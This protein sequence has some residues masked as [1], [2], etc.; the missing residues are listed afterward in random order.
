MKKLARFKGG[1]KLPG[2]KSL[3]NQAPIRDVVLPEKL[4]I[5]LRQH[6][7]E[8]A[9]PVVE[10][11]QRVLKGQ[12]IATSQAFISAPIHASS[13]GRV[14]E[15][16]KHPVAHQSG[17]SEPCIVIET[18][19]N[20]TWHPDCHV[21][22][23]V[24]ALTS[25]TIRSTIKQAG[26]VGLGGA[27]F[28]SAAKLKPTRPIDTLIINGVECEPYITCDDAIMRH[29]AKQ[30]LEGVLILRRL[31]DPVEAII[32]VEDNKPEAIAALESAIDRFKS[33]NR[34]QVNTIRVVAVPT[35]F[36]AGGE[37]QLIKVL[38]NREV[39]QHGL[40]YEVGVVCLNVGTTVAIYNAVFKA[41]PLVSRIV[42]VTGEAVQRP[43][44]YKVLI[45]TPVEHLLGQAGVSN[46]DKAQLKPQLIMG[47]PMMGQT[48]PHAQVPIVKA[49]NCILVKNNSK[50]EMPPSMPCI[51]CGTCAA[52]CPMQLLPQQLYWHARGNHF[53]KLEHYHLA[54]CIEC[55]CCSV[56]C[57]SRIP[58]VQYFRYAKSELRDQ[59][60]KTHFANQ[61][62]VR[63]Q[64]REARLERIK[65]EQEERKARRREARKKKK[66]TEQPANSR[67]DT[68]KADEKEPANPKQASVG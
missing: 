29:Y 13:S 39:P 56:V 67:S 60:I 7:G 12:L 41:E 10:V 52:A 20:D 6:I 42:T 68:V 47:G 53:E 17:L 55:G 46:S 48:L 21:D 32:A 15:I 11:G 45:G 35:I 33:D 3:S 63:M 36:P 4:I 40:P 28:P 30:V 59:T 43:G 18:D 16:G 9:M 31:I 66:T 57:P 2:F 25:D 19:G 44:N 54:D 64:A 23:S 22:Q 5:P 26:I 62:R 61:S 51:R 14:V 24:E 65:R 27:V 49:A 37:K 34:G 1:I 50:Q 58:L 8:T 38:T